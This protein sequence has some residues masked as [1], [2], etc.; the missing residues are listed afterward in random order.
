MKHLDGRIEHLK[1]ERK[2]RYIKGGI[3]GVVSILLLAAYYYFFNFAAPP[4]QVLINLS[5]GKKV[6]D[7]IQVN[8][9]ASK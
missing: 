3:L 1:Q 8:R 9:F 7:Q 4:P 2:S 6:E 5:E